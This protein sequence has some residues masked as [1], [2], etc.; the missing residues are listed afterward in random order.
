MP[1]RMPDGPA[2][3]LVFSFL[4]PLRLTAFPEFLAILGDLFVDVRGRLLGLDGLL[5]LDAKVCEVPGVVGIM[6]LVFARV[7]EPFLVVVVV[8][9]AHDALRLTWEQLSAWEGGVQPHSAHLGWFSLRFSPS[10]ADTHLPK[11]CT[12]H[13]SLSG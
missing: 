8:L 10:T 11:S 3:G 2:F 13:A 6:K 4:T 5:L 9:L 1:T 12:N 7:G